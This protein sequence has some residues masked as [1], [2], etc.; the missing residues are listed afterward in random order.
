MIPYMDRMLNDMSFFLWHVAVL[1]LC[2]TSLD[3]I[4][5]FES[6]KKMKEYRE[7]QEKKYENGHYTELKKK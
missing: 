4:K 1:I 6:K 2:I 3:I 5:R 7:K